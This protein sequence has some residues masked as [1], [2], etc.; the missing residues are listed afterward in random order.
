MENTKKFIEKYRL[1]AK[2]MTN[3]YFVVMVCNVKGKTYSEG[4]YESTPVDSEYYSL[5]QFD[6]I[7]NAIS[8]LGFT[9]K[10]YF[11][12]NDFISDYSNGKLK[13]NYP[14][15]ILVLNSA[16]KG[17]TEGRKSLIPAFC[18][19]NNILHTNSNAYTTSFARNKYHWFSVLKTGGYNVSESWLYDYHCGWISGKKPPQGKKVICKLNSESSS[20]GLNSNNIF[21][22]HNN[23]EIYIRNMSKE[24]Q[25]RVIVQEFIEGREVEVPV[26][27]NDQYGVSLSP[28]GIKIGEEKHLGNKIL[29][30]DIRGNNKF[31]FYSLAKEN[32]ELSKNIQRTTEMIAF[33]LGI[34]G[35]G[36]IDYRIDDDDNFFVTD[37]STNPH[38]TKSMSFYFAFKELGYTY[39]DVLATL[40]GVS[41]NRSFL[42]T[43]T[44]EMTLSSGETITVKRKTVTPIE[45][46]YL[47]EQIGWN[48]HPYEVHKAAIASSLYGVVVYDEKE[49]P[50]GMGRIVGD[51]KICFYLQ[52]I[53]VIPRW[54]N[55]GVGKIIMNELLLYTVKY[56]EPEAIVGL[57]AANQK[58]EKYYQK[59]GFK[60]RSDLNKGPGMNKEIY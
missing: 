5:K 26:I 39:E 59:F 43:L 18:D 36:R 1:F 30:Y 9:L 35:M 10:T 13:N 27:L 32:K 16:Q 42:S 31:S 53:G 48:T 45:W 3:D 40:L 52:D 49:N 2:K 47:R 12:E 57:M 41:M 11:D 33:E 29:D 60:S 17:I 21:L 37:V 54:Q 58:S 4:N 28:V 25:Q 46:I 24:F 6:E 15:K 34:F 19:L 22:F 55:K 38:I 8:A 14:K 44:E 56:A 23:K 20:I 50:I 7:T 51:D